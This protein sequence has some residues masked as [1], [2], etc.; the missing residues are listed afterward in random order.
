MRAQSSAPSARSTSTRRRS[1]PSRP[2]PTTLQRSAV[3]ENGER[4]GLKGDVTLASRQDHVS[5]RALASGRIRKS[6]AA[7]AR[8][9]RDEVRRQRDRAPHYGRIPSRR[10][11]QRQPGC[12]DWAISRAN[13]GAHVPP[14][15]VKAIPVS[16]CLLAPQDEPRSLAARRRRAPGFEPRVRRGLSSRRGVRTGGRSSDRVRTY[17]C[18]GETRCCR[19]M[20]LR[21]VGPSSSY[22]ARFAVCVSSCVE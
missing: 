14:A 11:T 6:A 2:T 3:G 20:G 17:D 16:L 9:D 1:I 12:R 10:A 4:P 21:W 5:S 15:A 13:L 19:V 7:R 22:V 8:P 18:A